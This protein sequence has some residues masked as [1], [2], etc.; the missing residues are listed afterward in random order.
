MFLDETGT[1]RTIPFKNYKITPGVGPL[2][3]PYWTIITDSGDKYI[4]SATEQ[5]RTDVTTPGIDEYDRD[6]TFISSWY[7]TQ[8]ISRN[9]FDV[10]NFEYTQTTEIQVK[11][12]SGFNEFRKDM[13][14]SYEPLCASQEVPP[15]FSPGPLI[16]LRQLFLSKISDNHGRV[17]DITN[18]QDRQDY[19]GA[20]RQSTIQIKDHLEIIRSVS[21][22]NN[23]YFGSGSETA[24]RLKL[25]RIEITGSDS[26][27]PEVYRFQ[28]NAQN[29]PDRFS[30]AQDLWGYFN[31]SGGGSMIPS[32]AGLPG[33]AERNPSESYTKACNL[34][35]IYYPTG[36]YEHF[37]YELHDAGST[38]VGGL[39]IK[40]INW[41]DDNTSLLKKTVYRYV[42]QQITSPLNS[43]SETYVRVSCG[44]ED[45][46][47]ST[48]YYVTRFAANRSQLGASAGIH[49]GYSQ[50]E[51]E[52]R[53]ILDASGNGKTVYR[54]STPSIATSY[55][56]NPPAF[57]DAVA[58]GKLLSK[59]ISLLSD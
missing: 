35:M 30:A 4:F 29:L 8:I 55:P 45:P 23:Q 48:C 5:T 1:P 3:A 36:G 41:H 13:L 47:P 17:L 19:V 20:F 18:V 11:T 33:G 44:T 32:M 56:F 14:G 21:F 38:Q 28:Y 53:D 2:A 25:D 39:R 46:F 22:Y 42:G 59:K 57:Q 34:E 43:T 58:L 16:F 31:G 7:L 12:N 6:K 10:Y 40:E 50:V 26:S 24:K 52:V 54:F 9:G 49:I 27:E 15:T 51:E 37:V